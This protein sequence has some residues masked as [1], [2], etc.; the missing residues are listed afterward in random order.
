MTLHPDWDALGLLDYGGDPR[1][2]RG[3]NCCDARVS[4]TI[5]FEKVTP[6]TVIIDAAIVESTAR[7]PSEG[8]EAGHPHLPARSGGA[9]HQRTRRLTDE[10]AQ[11]I[12]DTSGADSARTLSLARV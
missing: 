11:S 2:N 12:S 4:A 7:A 6:A 9:I 5:V 3:P 8:A 1:N 10:G